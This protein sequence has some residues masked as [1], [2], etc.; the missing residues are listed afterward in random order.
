M[1]DSVQ[2]LLGLLGIVSLLSLTI[3][4]FFRFR[5]EPT[6]IVPTQQENVAALEIVAQDQN[7][8]LP[9][10][11]PPTEPP[12]TAT[13]PSV[14]TLLP[15]PVVTP[16]PLAQ[17][18]IIPVSPQSQPYTIIS[19]DGRVISAI[20]NDGTN[21]RALLDVQT[22]T[23]LFVR[24]D[25]EAWG[26]VSPNGKQVALILTS[27]LL[28]REAQR[29][30]LK[31]S[32]WL[33]DLATS[34]LKL[35]VEDAVDPAWAPDSAKIAY[36]GPTGGLWLANVATGEAHEIYAVDRTR[37]DSFVGDI[38]WAPDS[39]RLVFLDK[40]F[41][42]YATLM[43]MNSNDRTS[44]K[45]LT[46]PDTQWPYL[47]QWS[48]DGNKIMFITWT[49][50]TVLSD[51]FFYS[52]WLTNPDGTEQ[53]Q[54]TSDMDTLGGAWSPDSRWIAF[55]SVPTFEAPEAYWD[56]WIINSAGTE[57]KRVTA[58]S[59]KK[60]DVSSLNWSPDGTQIIY[61]I[62]FNSVAVI[63]LSSSEQL[64]LSIKA[65]DFVITP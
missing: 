20:S 21:Q 2:R 43:V 57:L 44:A 38:S 9:T 7:S 32:L 64:N 10:L 24:N 28:P 53:T 61:G 56:L 36:M 11:I 17:P 54:L 52:L 4:A 12:P 51:R 40:V 1:K 19:H 22:Q 63:S 60:I 48:P 50:S 13:D 31:F 65:T 30:P 33:L 59:D 46:S 6:T 37:G 5:A 34:D 15:T 23:A 3:F 49:K 55:T 27:A 41:R 42:Q 29:E 25:G 62:E 8:P 58:N 35:L 14:P 18:P 26:K 47:P 16:I 45:P 39:Q